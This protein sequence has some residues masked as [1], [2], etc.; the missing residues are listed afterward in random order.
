MIQRTNFG[1]SD[2][3]DIRDTFQDL[4]VKALRE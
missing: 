3:S 2:A 1:N 4:A